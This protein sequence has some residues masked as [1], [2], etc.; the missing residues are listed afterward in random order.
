MFAKEQ[1]DLNLENPRVWQEVYKVMRFWLDKG[2][3]GF[4]VDVIS[5]LSKDPQYADSPVSPYQQY[6]SYY[7]G[8]P[9]GHENMSI[10]NK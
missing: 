9:M 7:P 5:L 4:R 2:V 6:G 8:L 10:C 1:P 3:D